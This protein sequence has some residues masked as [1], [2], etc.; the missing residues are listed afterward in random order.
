MRDVRGRFVHV[1]RQLDDAVHATQ[2]AQAARSPVVI[3]RVTSKFAGAA[4]PGVYF[5]RDC[6]CSLHTDA[7]AFTGSAEPERRGR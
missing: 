1:T 4:F 2:E 3:C 5:N 6:P 7:A